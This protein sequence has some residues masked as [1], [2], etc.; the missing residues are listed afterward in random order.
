MKAS[1]LLQL[2][3]ASELHSYITFPGSRL[4]IVEYI[5]TMVIQSR[6]QWVI[7]FLKKGVKRL[8][9][10]HPKQTEHAAEQSPPA[11][12]MDEKDPPQQSSTQLTIQVLYDSARML[13]E[14]AERIK[15]AVESE[16]ALL[17]A[18]DEKMI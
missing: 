2:F 10:K 7:N 13:L 5:A 18:G 11:Y 3:F 12:S 4:I 15:C 8:S 16:K 17:N 14:G 6:F 9:L 1:Q